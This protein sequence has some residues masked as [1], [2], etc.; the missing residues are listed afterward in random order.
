[1]GS[2]KT[3]FLDVWLGFYACSWSTILSQALHYD[4]VRMQVYAAFF[5]HFSGMLCTLR[6]WL[7]V[8]FCMQNAQLRNVCANIFHL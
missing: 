5:L 4:R 8:A 7:D 3:I 1:M 2:I 6:R